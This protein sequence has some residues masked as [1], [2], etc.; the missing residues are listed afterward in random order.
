MVQTK[1]WLY[2][3]TMVKQS[4]KLVT[5]FQLTFRRFLIKNSFGSWSKNF[6][7]FFAMICKKLIKIQKLRQLSQ[8]RNAKKINAIIFLVANSFFPF[9]WGPFKFISSLAGG[10]ICNEMKNRLDRFNVVN[11]FFCPLGRVALLDVAWV[12]QGKILRR[13]SWYL[14]V[15]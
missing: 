8:S 7:S 4:L 1:S 10:T 2:L 12:S 6:I 9:C 15:W 5:L 11:N 3:S 14:L 13:E